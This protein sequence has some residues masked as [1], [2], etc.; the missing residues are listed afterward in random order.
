MLGKGAVKK[1]SDAENPQKKRPNV[2]DK[3]ARAERRSGL[4]RAGGSANK[5]K[6]LRHWRSAN[7]FRLW[8]RVVLS[9]DDDRRFGNWALRNEGEYMALMKRY[10]EGKDVRA[11]EYLLNKIQDILWNSEAKSFDPTFEDWDEDEDE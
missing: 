8:T 9:T 4:L 1:E 7:E 10:G 11:R 5:E 6:K 3:T 2:T